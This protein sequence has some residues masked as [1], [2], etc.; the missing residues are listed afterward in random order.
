[1]DTETRDRR[2]IPL[3]FLRAAVHYSDRNWQHS[4]APT[5]TERNKWPTIGVRF[6]VVLFFNFLIS[7]RAF[8]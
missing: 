2:T 6:F 1:M 3:R 7:N 5:R 8:I 4:R